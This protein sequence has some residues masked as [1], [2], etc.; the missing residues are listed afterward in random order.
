MATN[1]TP[2]PI[3]FDE[4]L[5]IFWETANTDET[6]EVQEAAMNARLD[7]LGVTPEQRVEFDRQL[8]VAFHNPNPRNKLMNEMRDR[9]DL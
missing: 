8:G 1:T 2:K 6:E 4:Y 5:D 3:S 9:G 7:A